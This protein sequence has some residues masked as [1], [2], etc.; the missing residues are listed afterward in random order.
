MYLAPFRIMECRR[1]I[2]V[3]RNIDQ[4]KANYSMP[5]KFQTALR[6]HTCGELTPV[7]AHEYVSL[8]GWVHRRRDLGQ[9]IFI[10]LRDRYGITQIVFNPDS[11]AAAHERARELRSEFVVQIY[12]KATPRAD[13]NV[14]KQIPTGAIEVVAEKIEIVSRAKTPPFELSDES[15][16]LDEDLRL[17]FRYL[18]LRRAYMQ[19]AMI[20]RHRLAQVVRNFFNEHHFIEVETPVLMKSTPEGAR[21]YLVPS[22]VHHGKFYALPQSPQIYKQL[23]MVS[24]YDRYY[25]IVKCFRDEDLRADRQP[26]F[27][28]VDVEMS[29]VDKEDVLTHIERL[30]HKIFSELKGI[31]LQLPL[32]RL[33]YEDAMTSYGTDKPDLRFG[34]KIIGIDH[35]VKNSDFKVFQDA[36]EKKDGTIGCIK[37]EGQNFSRKQLDELTDFVKPYGLKG[38]A[39]IK[40][41]ATGVQSSI[42][43]FLTEEML[44]GIVAQTQAQTG[45]TILIAADSIMTVQAALGNLRLHLAEKLN[46]IREDTWNLYWVVDF[47]LFAYDAEEKRW[48][49]MHHPFTAPLESD[50]E[51]MDTDRAHVR[52]KAYDLVLNGTEIG[53]GSIRI[54][55]KDVQNK[56]FDALGLSPEEREMKFGFLLKAFEY[57]VP[58]HG[59]IALGFDRIAALLTGR[60]SIRDVI[61]FPKT[62]SAVSLMDH[63]PSTVDVRQLKELGIGLLPEKK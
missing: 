59:G 11:N 21:D 52:A 63:A 27:T 7:H 53:G 49:A 39:A 3:S 2:N 25:Q 30:M 54:H 43:K 40:V 42:A 56:M 8:I 44:Q 45:D 38:L 61:A 15:I 5:G 51:K 29:F 13:G 24:G 58:P 55:N 18:D 46:L 34:M 47:P 32:P 57:G 17:E 1:G 37:I 14:N 48:A 33:S 50:L 12:G 28:Q 26:E 41:E 22:R 23:L 10:D 35:L 62:N 4:K 31:E 20:F 36:L 9:L 16:K 60:K 6:T 19:E